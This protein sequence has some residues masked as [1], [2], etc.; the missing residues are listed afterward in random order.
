MTDERLP[1]MDPSSDEASEAQ[2]R[3]VREQGVPPSDRPGAA[4]RRMEIGAPSGMSRRS[5]RTARL[6][7]RM[8]PW[9]TAR[10]SSSG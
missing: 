7:T 2:L 3:L 4:Q 1:P 5:C 9:E 8:Q 6:E 10:P